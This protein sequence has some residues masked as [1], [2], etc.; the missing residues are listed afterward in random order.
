ME[1]EVSGDGLSELWDVVRDGD[2][3]AIEALLVGDEEHPPLGC[4][5]DVMDD[6]G[7]T[8]LHWLAVEG[9]QGVV[10]WLVDEVGAELSLGDRRYGQ[11]ALHFAACKDHGRTAQALLDLGADVM[12]R[13]AA[14]WTPL[15]VAARACAIDV[16]SVLLGALPTD[17][18][19]VCGPGQQTP[20]HRAAFWGHTEV[21]TL[22]L[23]GGASRAAVDNR[24]RTPF[25]IV[26][27]SGDR[28]GELPALQK[29][30]RP[31]APTY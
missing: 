8:P 14:G 1:D 4:P 21:V 15:H 30:L 26:C 6:A 18:I 5:I 20:L 22:L 9:H 3:A 28:R 31:P 12:C 11:T 17:R 16:A 29:A 25:D 10:Q 24:G 23:Q 13:D 27:D 19:D 2:R 7:M